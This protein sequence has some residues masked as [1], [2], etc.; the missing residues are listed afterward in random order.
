MSNDIFVYQARGTYLFNGEE[1]QQ[2]GWVNLF[3]SGRIIG[4]LRDSNKGHLNVPKLVLGLFKGPSLKYIKVAQEGRNLYTV[5]WSMKTHQ[6][7][8]EDALGGKYEGKWTFG[9]G[10]PMEGELEK[11]MS[12]GLDEDAILALSAISVE[13]LG[14]AYFDERMMQEV[15]RMGEQHNRTGI[16]NFLKR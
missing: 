3:P 7:V 16:L 8:A 5:V 11:L 9:V 2:R 4:I 1:G 14:Q 15:E 13:K 10:L 6:Y 12:D